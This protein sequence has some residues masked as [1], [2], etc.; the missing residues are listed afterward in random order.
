MNALLLA[1]L[2]F[3]SEYEFRTPGHIVT[4]KVQYPEPYRGQPLGFYHES[5]PGK[6][7]CYTGQCIDRFVGVAAVVNFTMTRAHAKAPKPAA[8][9]EV[10]TILEQSVDMPPTPVFAVTQKVVNGQVG[11]IQVMGYDEDGVAEPERARMRA[12]SL[13][14]MWRRASQELYLNG[15]A[16]PFA[17]I[18]WRHTMSGVAIVSVT[19]TPAG[20]SA[21]VRERR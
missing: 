8:L 13:T 2:L 3:D 14:R 7:R 20:A 18:E 15:A 21:T 4:M 6:R 11:D 5:E 9:R 19:A 16:T 10:V 12:E 1:I 17:V